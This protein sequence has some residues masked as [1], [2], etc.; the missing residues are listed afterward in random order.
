[1]FPIT[2]FRYIPFSYIPHL[3]AQGNNIHNVFQ[4]L[5]GIRN[6]SYNFFIEN[7]TIARFFLQQSG[8]ILLLL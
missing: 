4:M 5:N 2:F 3:C 8:I 7:T 6:I 1:M